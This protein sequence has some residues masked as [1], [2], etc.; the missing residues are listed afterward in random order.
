MLRLGFGIV[1]NGTEQDNGATGTLA[2]STGGATAATFGSAITTLSQGFPSQYYP[3]AWPTYNP[4]FY[5]TG[6]PT[7]GA[8]PVATDRNAGR[9][10]RQYQWSIGLQREITKDLVVEATYVGNRG[11]WWNS[12]GLICPNC[13]TPQQLAKSGL[14]LNNA[15]DRTLLASPVSAANAAARGFSFPYGGFPATA[16]VA[17]PRAIRRAKTRTVA[18]TWPSAMAT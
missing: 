5:P 17:S 4:A 7:P 3:P 6:F 13:I 16:T 10:A 15:S 11:A 8:G 12:G 1:Y 18:T 14:D 9:P 2:S